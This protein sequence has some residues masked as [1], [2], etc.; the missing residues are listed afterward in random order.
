MTVLMHA[1]P[2]HLAAKYSIV[3]LSIKAS[4]EHGCLLIY[5]AWK[6]GLD[7]GVGIHY[8]SKH[9]TSTKQIVS[10]LLIRWLNFQPQ[11]LDAKEVT[12]DSRGLSIRSSNVGAVFLG[13]VS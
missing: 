1:D 7:N 3:A 4:T 12:F 5:H 10:V 9:E 13:W 11:A 8:N 6:A 2:Q